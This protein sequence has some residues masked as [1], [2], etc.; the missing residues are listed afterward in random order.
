MVYDNCFECKGLYLNDATNCEKHTYPINHERVC[1][2]R[3]VAYN[4]LM[5]LRHGVRE[6]TMVYQLREYLTKNKRVHC[7]SK[8]EKLM[9]DEHF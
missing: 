4:D 3:H 5:K 8:L 2:Y 6:I 7:L 9:E 1:V